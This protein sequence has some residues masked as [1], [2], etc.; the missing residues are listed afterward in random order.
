MALDLLKPQEEYTEMLPPCRITPSMR[1]RLDEV[2]RD[3]RLTRS[4]IQRRA[5]SLF[6]D[7]VRQNGHSASTRDLTIEIQS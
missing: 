2:V 6:L 5:L 4:D 3:S 7:A 1:R